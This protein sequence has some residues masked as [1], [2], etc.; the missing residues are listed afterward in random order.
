MPN[1]SASD[2]EQVTVTAAL[3]QTR[4]GDPLL[5]IRQMTITSA[6]KDACRLV[7]RVR[8]TPRISREQG[9]P[10]KSKATQGKEQKTIFAD[11]AALG[12]FHVEQSAVV[13]DR[14]FA[15]SNKDNQHSS[16]RAAVKEREHRRTARCDVPNII[17]PVI[18]VGVPV[19]SAVKF[20]DPSARTAATITRAPPPLNAPLKKTESR[21]PKLSLKVW[22]PVSRLPS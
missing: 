17:W 12:S 11:A 18:A 7:T 20:D 13:S 9:M 5:C 4:V 6:L 14:R 2:A 3:G 19:K 8:E 10:I 1:I 21:W 15:P 22:R 16:Y